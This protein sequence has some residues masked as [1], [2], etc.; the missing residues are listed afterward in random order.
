MHKE[1]KV[2][3]DFQGEELTFTTGNLAFRA[4]ATVK[5]QLGETVVL[6]IVTVDK[7][8]SS[9]DYFP[10]GVEYIEKFYAGGI[11]SG[12][13]FVKRERRP[14][15]EAVL[16]ARQVD[17]S[18]RSLF[19][20]GFKRA[21]SV[22]ITVL[23]YD[24]VHDPAD[25]AVTAASA[26]LMMSPAPFEGPSAGVSVGIKKDG[27]LVVNPK[28]GDRVDLDGHY[29]VALKDD[30]VLNIEGWS[31]EA[32]EDK[33]DELLDLAAESVKPLF[34]VQKNL[35]EKFGKKKVDFEELPIDPEIL[36]KVEKNYGKEIDEGLFSGLKRETLFSEIAKK[37]VEEN[38]GDISKDNARNS[39]EYLARKYMRK[40]VLEKEKRV[41]GRKLDEVRKIEVA[42]GVL[43]RVHGSALFTRGITQAMSIVT[44]GST[45]LSQTLESFEGEEEKRFMHHY[46]G[47]SYSTGEAGRFSYYPGRR[48]I[49]HGHITESAVK[50][51]LPAEE[52]FP[53]TI[54]VV[55]EILSQN[56]SSSMAAACGTSMALMD[57]G[58]PIKKAIGG[59]AVGLVT[60][61]NDVTKYK[62][63]TDIEGVE[64]FY[65]DMDFKIVGTKE[66][67]TAIQLDNKL[68]GV[69]LQI[70]KEA[71][72]QSRQGREQVL[73]VMEEVIKE[74]RPELSKHAPKVDVVKVDPA[75]I[76]DLIGPGGKNIRAIIEECEQFGEIDIDIQESGD[77]YITSVSQES[78]DRAIELIKEIFEEAEIGKEY[79]GIVDR[80][81][82]Y[83]AFV[84]VTKNI[85]GLVHVSEI[86]DGFIK[87]VSG[88]LKVG[89]KVK[90]KVIGIDDMGRIKLSMKG[91]NPEIEKKA[92]ESS[93]S[94]NSRSP[95]NF[96]KEGNKRFS[97][98]NDRNRNTRRDRY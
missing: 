7:E 39:V 74:P 79:E 65:G 34:E 78:R 40:S 14:S 85:S 26:A 49:G 1:E 66:G 13:R 92:A 10:L 82:S 93:K 96:S 62:L 42:A 17:H 71:M 41:S 50:A 21:V 44:L 81:E 8:E 25:L 4:D 12:S 5:V 95:Q 60:D 90:V 56:G 89:D 80:V 83:G 22:V 54:R 73:S 48:E 52:D 24:D 35:Q 29:I 67:I 18:I 76:G 86:T 9:L 63:L 33:M 31:N 47:P 23:S 45:R 98:G 27:N 58:V 94:D 87:D 75:K 97:A 70:I 30:R 32:D 61:D 64:D 46:N 38:E 28:N 72:R 20:K 88:V 36:E 37:I 11:I 6:A 3:I 84:D 16:K 91:L 59:I 15:D 57:A 43:P 68:Q 51:I 53:Y 19:P 77:V 2:S 69:P 55:S